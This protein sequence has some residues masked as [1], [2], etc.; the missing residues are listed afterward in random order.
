MYCVEYVTI[1]VLLRRIQMSRG[2]CLSKYSHVVVD[3][4]HERSVDSDFLLLLLREYKS[5]TSSDL[6]PRVI[7]MSATVDATA[8][9]NY[10][11]A[12]TNKIGI[13]HIPGRTFPVDPIF[14]E[15]IIEESG[16]EHPV[17]EYSYND[18]STIIKHCGNLCSPRTIVSLKYI[19]YSVVNYDLIHHVIKSE[20]NKKIQYNVRI[21]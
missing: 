15:D 10:W 5:R 7:L 14:I 13:V 6:F 20:I 4:V 18:E 19:D 3:E 2:E 21:S 12:T 9:S 11:R 16:Y 17:S 1:G 8:V